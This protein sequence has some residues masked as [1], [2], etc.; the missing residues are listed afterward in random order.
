MCSTSSIQAPHAPP[1]LSRHQRAP[2]RHPEIAV[3]RATVQLLPVTRGLRRPTTCPPKPG[4][5]LRSRLGPSMWSC[6][7]SVNQPVPMDDRQP[8]ASVQWSE[9]RRIRKMSL[10]LCI[11]L[12]ITM[13]LACW[14]RGL[15]S[16]PGLQA[17]EICCWRTSRSPVCS[18]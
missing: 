18:P 16:F 9:S 15:W 2:L 14:R 10:F 6:W 3:P 12:V 1:R 17:P 8:P 5:A 13:F 7:G 11:F 4:T